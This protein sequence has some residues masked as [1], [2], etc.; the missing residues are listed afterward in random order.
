MI[1]VFWGSLIF[2]IIFNEL[3]TPM[4]SDYTKWENYKNQIFNSYIKFV[5]IFWE[6]MYVNFKNQSNLR[7]IFICG[8]Q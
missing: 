5:N 4:P 2:K 3:I 7:V 8:K 1:N 6:T